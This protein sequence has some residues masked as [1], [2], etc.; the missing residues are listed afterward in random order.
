MKKNGAS[1]VKHLERERE[2]DYGNH[3]RGVVQKRIIVEKVVTSGGA[4]HPI[5][6]VTNQVM[7]FPFQWV[8]E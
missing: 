6:A 1:K 4:C 8:D 5:L 3:C 2:R 7:L